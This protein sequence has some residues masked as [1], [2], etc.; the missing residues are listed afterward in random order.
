MSTWK[1]LKKN[2]Q[3]KNN[4]KLYKIIFTTLVQAEAQMLGLDRNH[5]LLLWCKSTRRSAEV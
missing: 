1:I 5:F 4:L 2:K 3:K